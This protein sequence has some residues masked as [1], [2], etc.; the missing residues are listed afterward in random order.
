MNLSRDNVITLLT[1]VV[2]LA[3]VLVGGITVIIGEYDGDVRQ[4]I[5]DISLVAAALGIGAG[6]GRGIATSRGR[7]R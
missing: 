2:V 5:E 6:V 3:V 1:V 7:A 4:W